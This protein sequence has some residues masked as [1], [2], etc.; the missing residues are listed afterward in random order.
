MTSRHAKVA[1]TVEPLADLT[2]PQLKQLDE[3]I[4]SILQARPTPTIGPVGI[5]A[6]A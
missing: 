6:H 5:G 1:I 4:A 3:P 2:T